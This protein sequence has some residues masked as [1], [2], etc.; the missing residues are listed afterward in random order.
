MMPQL[1]G[2]NLIDDARGGGAG[3]RPAVANAVSGVR[4]QSFS[5]RRPP[6]LMEALAHLV[7]H[8]R[9]RVLCCLQRLLA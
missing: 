3:M 1:L 7:G 8:S 4:R 5:D 2:L 9:R 6:N